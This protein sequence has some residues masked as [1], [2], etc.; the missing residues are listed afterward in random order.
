LGRKH[1]TIA[2]P[3][4]IYKVKSIIINTVEFIRSNLPSIDEE[5][6]FDLRLIFSELLCN[7]VIHGNKN[8]SNK[9]VSLTVELEDNTVF[10]IISDEGYG[11]DYT[12][13]LVKTKSETSLYKDRGR[14]ILLVNSLTDS[15]IF[16]G[17]G[18]E[19][20]FYKKVNVHGQNFDS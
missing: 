8:D 10:S 16:N 11:F 13:L 20:K 7:A 3:S 2:F 18:N 14:G 19:I 6:L 17:K 15:M 1:F 12:N 9:N 5:D 4:E